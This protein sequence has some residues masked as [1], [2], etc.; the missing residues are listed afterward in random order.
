MQR[1]Q[2]LRLHEDIG[3]VQNFALK[4]LQPYVCLLLRLFCHFR[5]L[6]LMGFKL[7]FT[8]VLFFLNQ[9]AH[10]LDE[11]ELLMLTEREYKVVSKYNSWIVIYVNF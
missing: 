5:F 10:S 3:A 11:F 9:I 4:P 8:A 2:I 1:L 6:I 7:W